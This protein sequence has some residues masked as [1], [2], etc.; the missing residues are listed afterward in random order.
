MH[1]HKNIT[2]ILFQFPSYINRES[3]YACVWHYSLSFIS[4]FEIL[5]PWLFLHIC[6]YASLFALLLL[7]RR[8]ALS[9]ICSFL[10]FCRFSGSRRGIYWF[11][12]NITSKTW[13]SQVGI[14]NICL[15]GKLTHT[16]NPT[17]SI[18]CVY[19]I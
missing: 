4:S 1:T 14:Y 6:S 17:P 12:G 18:F 3:R 11:F 16:R 19:I 2:M 13:G 8:N 5:R 9:N 7:L 15:N 10:F